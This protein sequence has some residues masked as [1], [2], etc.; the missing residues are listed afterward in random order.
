MPEGD[1]VFRAA[2]SLHRALA[3]RALTVSD[4]RV[5]RYATVDLRGQTV[6]E[7][8]AKGK[9]LLAR[10]D[11]G[12]TVHTHLKM[13]GSWSVYG[14]GRRWSRTD[15]RIRAVLANVE[16]DTVGRLLGLVEILPTARE[17]DALGHLGPDLLGPDWD[18][19]EALRRLRGAPDRSISDALLDQRNLAGIGNL[20][21]NEVLFLKGVNPWARVVQVDD[22]AALV[23]LAQRMLSANVK[24]WSQTTTGNTQRGA[25][26]WVFERKGQPCR[27][28]GAVIQAGRLGEP[29]VERITYWCPHCQPRAEAVG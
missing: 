17:A 16:Y 22:L 13:E 27:R 3:G 4:F 18:P 12:M 8:V 11:A 1:T 23:E 20:Y 2:R 7:V 5:P 9:H 14:P 25:R 28:C 6:T 10:T 15:H 21:R 24:H 19:D 26:H 29:G